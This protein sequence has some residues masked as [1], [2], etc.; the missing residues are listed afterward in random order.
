[1]CVESLPIRTHINITFEQEKKKEGH[2]CTQSRSILQ[3][4]KKLMK[5]TAQTS[6]HAH[7]LA[8]RKVARNAACPS[9]AHAMNDLSTQ[10]S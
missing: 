10:Q 6:R 7:D 4:E 3:M 8:R 1:M 9:S 5:L 2:N